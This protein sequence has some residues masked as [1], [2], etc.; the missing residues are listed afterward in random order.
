MPS[1]LLITKNENYTKNA[2]GR[3]GRTEYYA[4]LLLVRA[5]LITGKEFLEA[6]AKAIEQLQA[7]PG[8]FETSLEEASFGCMDQV[9]PPGRRTPSTIK[10]RITTR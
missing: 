8:R 9:L 4:G 1:G 6:K 2:L 3:R 7:R 10:S 5:G